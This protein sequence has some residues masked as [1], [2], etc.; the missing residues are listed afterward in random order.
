[1]FNRPYVNQL[2]ELF[3]SGSTLEEVSLFAHEEFDNGL[4]LRE[5]IDNMISV[6]SQIHLH[7][8]AQGTK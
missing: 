7:T 4:M 3:R 5:E 8:L 6:A 2:L 1:M